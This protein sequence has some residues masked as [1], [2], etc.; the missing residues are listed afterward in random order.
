[1]SD[2]TA[3]SEVA[4]ALLTEGVTASRLE[5]H[6]LKHLLSRALRLVEES[7]HKEHL[8]EVAGDV[9]KGVPKRLQAL[10]NQLDKTSYV[11][12]VLGEDYLRNRLSLSDR[13]QVD[14]AVKDAHPFGSR[15]EKRSLVERVLSRVA[16]RGALND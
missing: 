10:E 7:D 13:Y 4:W 16:A 3:S 6:R 5:A 12:T 15:R 14:D 9:I 1:M 8:Y 2:K 11:L